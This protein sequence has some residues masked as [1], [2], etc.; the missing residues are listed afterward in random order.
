VTQ[1]PTAAE[2]PAQAQGWHRLHPLSPLIQAGRVVAGLFTVLV[3]TFAQSGHGGYRAHIPDVILVVVLAAA[4]L[5]RWV[6]TRWRLDG[7]TLRIE[8]GLFRRDSQQL[9]VARIQAIDVVRP[10]LARVLG[11]AELRIRLAGSSTKAD[12]RLAYLTEREAA[13]VRAM[14]LA[15]HQPAP[16]QHQEHQE[17]QEE[18]YEPPIC[19]VPAGPLIGSSILQAATQFIGLGVVVAIVATIAPRILVGLLST[20]GLYAFGL[21]TAAWRRVSSRYGFT[22]TLSA[23]R[24]GPRTAGRERQSG[25][26]AEPEGIRITRGLLGTVAETV[27]VRRI[28]AVRMVQPVLWRPFGWCRLQVDLAGAGGKDEGSRESRKELL[29][30]GTVAEA[31]YLARLVLRHQA[32]PLHKPPARAKIKAPLSYHF[33]AAGHDEIMAVTTTGRLVKT[34]VWLRLEKAQ[35]IRLVQGPLQRALNLANVH[36]DA[37]GKEVHA[38][39]RD[40]P[41]S[42][43]RELLD[44]LATL[45]RTARNVSGLVQHGRM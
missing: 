30:V 35:S 13:S 16:A 44:E 21:A 14:L 5:V 37:A 33:L 31:E 11:L 42:Q 39:F 2:V 29:P 23:E 43:A 20:L 45:S 8:T 25:P 1:A 6:V 17:Q 32:P 34:T 26:P 4:A 19:Q 40:R 10:F 41:V 22:V 27:P 28:Q 36:A 9:P 12:G 3:V 18:Q 24:G 38:V 15:V 7:S